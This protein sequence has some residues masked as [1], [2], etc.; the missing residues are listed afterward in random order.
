MIHP[1][2]REFTASAAALAVASLVGRP[3]TGQIP[4]PDLILHNGRITT[5]DPGRPE[6]TAVAIQAGRFVAVGGER[7][8]MPLAS[9]AT[10]VVDLRRRRVI[11][12][13][14]DSHIHLIRGG[15][16]Y[17]M[18]LRWDGVPSL[19]TGMRML[20][21]QVLRTPPPQW[22]R[23]V[24]GFSEFQFVERR[25][26]SLDEINAAAPETPVFILNVYD[27]ALLNAAAV[28]ALGWTRETP[29]PPGSVIERDKAGNPTGVIVA[30]PGPK[31]L[32]DTLGR[33]PRLAYEDELNSTRQ[34][35]RELNR[36]GITSV[37]DAGGGAHRYP[38][39]YRVI[40]DLHRQGLLTL[41]IAYNL[42]PQVPGQEPADIQA[43]AEM[44]RYGEGDGFYRMNGG[45][46]NIVWAAAD[47]ENF[48]EPRPDLAASMEEQL[49]RA[50]RLMLAD[51]WP[52]RL[53]ATYDE[54]ISRF[55]DVFERIDRD[56][57][58]RGVPWI[59]DH[60]ETASPRSLD[61]IAAL[62]GSI[63]V[64][65]RMAISGEYFVGRYGAEAAREAPPIRRMLRAGIPV[66]AGSDATRAS[67]YN[68]WVTL[69]WL[70]TGK[71]VGGLPLYGESNR[72]DRAEAL[73]LSTAAGAAFS[74]EAGRKGQIALGQYAD[75]AVLEDDYFTVAEDRIGNLTSVMTVV[76][77]R[78]V[79]AVDDFASL[80][81]P[82][83]PVS[84][85]WSP[86]AAYGGY[87]RQTA[88]G[89]PAHQHGLAAH[90]CTAACAHPTAPGAGGWWMD[91]CICSA[92]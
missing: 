34:F 76:D 77:G 92:V 72:L 6:V 82:D 17:N 10:R 50:V 16:H 25:L 30:K 44:V 54:S 71:T 9:P 5:V 21:E 89:H 1:N 19:A 53:H 7:E 58:L 29:T 18:E 36:L 22:V 23:V 67:G 59:I 40:E 79:Y 20:R 41:R 45:G 57:P 88:A 87:W 52:F 11:P 63:A 37:I 83:L 24:G 33:A 26:P 51:K 38:D 73:R 55:L 80:G 27:R 15:L 47:F 35:M 43:W 68:P 48:L 75:L 28:R 65:Q 14:N 78:I 66:A 46:E 39:D 91:P 69:S 4:A 81:P 56:I 84:P 86:V 85:G 3:A 61:R 2:R 49:E 62:A 90:L 70:V 60:A 64:Q 12:G 42:F 74:G 8:V 13:L 31:I 32:L